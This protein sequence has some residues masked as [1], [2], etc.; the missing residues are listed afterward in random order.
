MSLYNMFG[1]DKTLE[2]NGIW[3]EIDGEAS[4]LIRRIGTSNSDYVRMLRAKTKP[5]NR[6]IENHTL[7]PKIEQ[8]IYLDVF[9]STALLDWKNVKDKDGKVIEFSKSA[10]IELFSDLPELL[11]YLMNFASEFENYRREELEDDAKN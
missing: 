9:V 5:H 3:L 8:K 6:S 11:K 10:A 2:T 1:T 4:F 7:D